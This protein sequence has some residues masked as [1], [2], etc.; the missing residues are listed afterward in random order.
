MDSN[1]LGSD[2]V[3]NLVDYLVRA[4]DDG[5]FFAVLKDFI[6]ESLEIDRITLDKIIHIIEQKQELGFVS[7]NVLIDW[8]FVA[9]W[10]VEE[11]DEE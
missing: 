4:H 2:L 7:T 10:L 5:N 8:H 3:W 9:F 11:F 1:D 6:Q